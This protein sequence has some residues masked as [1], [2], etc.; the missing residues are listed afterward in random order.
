MDEACGPRL[1][2]RC[3]QRSGAYEHRIGVRSEKA[4]DER[5]RLEEAADLATTG[6]LGVVVRDDT[7]DGRHEIRDNRWPVKPEWDGEVAAVRVSQARR[8]L[9]AAHGTL[10]TGRVERDQ[11]L[12]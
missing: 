11:R 4:H 2:G 12:D 9:S 3:A 7:V 5:V 1:M 6:G 8:E 10:I